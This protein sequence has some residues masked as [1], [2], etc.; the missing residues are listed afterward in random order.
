MNIIRRPTT[1]DG[2][3]LWLKKIAD[4]LLS[5]QTP[6]NRLNVAAAALYSLCSSV[7]GIDEDSVHAD[8]SD[9]TTAR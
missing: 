9:G 4:E 8:V 6:D 5:P 3:S 2:Y 1:A 7:T